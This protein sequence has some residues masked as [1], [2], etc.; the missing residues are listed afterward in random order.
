[1]SEK[2]GW[3][4]EI[5]NDTDGIPNRL[6]ITKERMDVFNKLLE[7][8]IIEKQLGITE[9]MQLISK[10]AHN[11]NESAYVFL[12]LGG[13]LE[14]LRTAPTSMLMDIISKRNDGQ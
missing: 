14:K 8:C 6:G 5:V 9:T 7:H 1:M 10:E 3:H 4:V 2:K 11:A 13:I 12:K